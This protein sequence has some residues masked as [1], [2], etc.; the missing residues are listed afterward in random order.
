MVDLKGPEGWGERVGVAG[1]E[2]T[3][4]EDIEFGADPWTILEVEPELAGVTCAVGTGVDKPLSGS[5]SLTTLAVLASFISG[6]SGDFA[7]GVALLDV[8][9]KAPL[10]DGADLDS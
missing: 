8:N 3:L 9:E 1:E 2:L 5:D 6:V 10:L 7:T 4:E